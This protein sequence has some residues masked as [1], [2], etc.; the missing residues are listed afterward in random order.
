VPAKS[1]SIHPTSGTKQRPVWVVLLSVGI[2]IVLLIPLFSGDQR[3]GVGAEARLVDRRWIVTAVDRGGVAQQAGVRVG[4][5]IVRLDGK[6]P[7]ERHKADP[8]LRLDGSRVWTVLRNNGVL[9]LRM[10]AQENVSGSLL[11]LLTAL[12]FWSIGFAILLMKPHDPLV[13]RLYSLNI[14]M[15]GVLGLSV[16]AS[17]DVAWVR[18]VEVAAYS[19]LPAL[20][21]SSFTWLAAGA[22]PHG[23]MGWIIQSLF[24]L[25]IGTGALYVVA[26][27]TA[28]SWF[29]A[30]GELVLVLVAVGFLSGLASLVRACRTPSPEEVHNQARDILVGTAA[31]VL[32]VT[33]LSIAPVV[34]SGAPLVAPQ[35]AA[36]S[37]ICL[38]LALAYAVVRHQLLGIDIVVERTLVYGLMTALLTGAYALFL[39]I[40]AQSHFD[41][42][43]PDLALLIA[44][45]AAVT[46][47]FTLVRDRLHG[48]I[49]Q[50]IYRDRYDYIKTLRLLGSELTAVGPLDRAL[51]D[52]VELLSR[53]MNLTGAV[54]LLQ[55]PDG[56][57]VIRAVCGIYV[58]PATHA[59]LLNEAE[60]RD[61]RE[62]AH[63][64]H[65]IELVANDESCGLLHLGP[66]R[67]HLALSPTDVSFVQAVAQQ[68]A[69][70]VANAVLVERLRNKV[71][72]LEMLRDRLLHVEEDERKHVA[73]D[74]HD[75][76][77]QSILEIG[78]QIDALATALEAPRVPALGPKLWNLAELNRAAAYELRAVCTD[79]YPS[80]LAHL[81]LVPACK[82]IARKT[83]RDECLEVQF[84]HAGFPPDGR[85]R[86]EV[87]EALYRIAREAVSNVVR[88][89]HASHACISLT[90]R[91][92]ATRLVIRDDGAGFAVPTSPAALVR[93]GHIGIATMRER[94]EAAGGTLTVSSVCG[95]GTEVCACVHNTDL[96]HDAVALPEAVGT[97][98]HANLARR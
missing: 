25:G 11:L 9:Q 13:R 39:T 76:A 80:E 65:W 14:A 50:L 1:R 54:I 66:K 22:R 58:D 19:V 62:P 10:S 29:D 48:L 34:F 23:R 5:R 67:T 70:V 38:P 92:G 59:T 6:L 42:S 45:F 91:D 61:N 21:L 17:L 56:R 27:F 98:V 52:V 84:D 53:T 46:L 94:A 26:G 93:L 47:S 40:I 68:A 51:T 89:A 12:G 4:D 49:D 31:A 30:L 90:R 41:R 63:A 55:T 43:V 32:P 79:L 87:E 72:E 82:D 15:A 81:G 73:Q 71:W 74:L 36:L 96:V 78:R 35:L 37:T 95:T 60:D 33:I 8:G 44:F 77:L 86:S 69:V 24:A 7:A 85:L 3:P 88:H 83:S 64:A 16:P 57:L 75:G 18:A 97:E 28:S 2:L 20:F